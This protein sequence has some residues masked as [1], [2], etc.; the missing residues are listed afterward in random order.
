MNLNKLVIADFG[1]SNSDIAAFPHFQQVHSFP[2]VIFYDQT[3]NIEIGEEALQKAG[4]GDLIWIKTSARLEE[5]ELKRH[6][7]AFTEFV[8][9]S[10][11]RIK[12]Q[13]DNIDLMMSEPIDMTPYARQKIIEQLKEI[14]TIKRVYFLP[15]PIGTAF[16]AEFEEKCIL[17]DIGDG[18]TSVQAFQGKAPVLAKVRT[19]RKLVASQTFRGGRTMTF[20]TAEILAEMCGIELNVTDAGSEDYKYMIQ[21]KHKI[22]SEEHEVTV[23][24]ETKKL[25]VIQITTEMQK[26]IISCLFS[27]AY[28]YPPV[29]QAIWDT[30]FTVRDL[31]TQ[32]IQKIWLTGK[33]FTSEAV[34]FHFSVML[35]E[36]LREDLGKLGIHSIEIKRLSNF[37]HSVVDGMKKIGPRLQKESTKWIDL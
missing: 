22:L 13:K 23:I 6:P 15:E 16:S 3:G 2:T 37:S 34:Y 18:N 31:S 9:L 27:P 14:K 36:H 21:L 26:R 25:K 4:T 5:E 1:T 8:E 11:R 17:V 30:A 19:G 20:T 28:D 10:L 33:P 7:D 29:H 24:D 12:L 35:R 32:L